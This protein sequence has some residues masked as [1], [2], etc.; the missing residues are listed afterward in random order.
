[1]APLSCSGAS[2]HLSQNTAGA[3]PEAWRSGPPCVV[4]WAKRHAL[5]PLAVAHASLE[6]GHRGSTQR[7]FTDLEHMPAAALHAAVQ[8]L[9]QA[10]IHSKE[11]VQLAALQQPAQ[12]LGPRQ[13]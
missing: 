11:V 3:R 8:G 4:C 10:G 2:G 6:Q 5:L 13:V 9:V 7:D 1:M 12:E